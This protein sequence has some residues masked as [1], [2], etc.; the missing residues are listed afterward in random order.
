MLVYYDIN[1]KE[2]DKPIYSLSFVEQDH[3]HLS[4]S[5]DVENNKTKIM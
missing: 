3:H 2:S 1:L 4:F 5:R